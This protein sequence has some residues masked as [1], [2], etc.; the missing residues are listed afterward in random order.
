MNMVPSTFVVD[1]E[2]MKEMPHISCQVAHS[3]ELWLGSARVMVI[4]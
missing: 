2:F 1:S 4:H 3:E